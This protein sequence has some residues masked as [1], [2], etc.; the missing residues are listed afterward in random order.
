MLLVCCAHRV[1]QKRC[2]KGVAFS[3]VQLAE[4]VLP[5]A[6]PRKRVPTRSQHLFSGRTFSRAS[7][8]RDA[9]RSDFQSELLRCGSRGG[10]GLSTRNSLYSFNWAASHGENSLPAMTSF[11]S[12]RPS[13][14]L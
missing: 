6:P 2:R 7:G 10:L 5:G 11:R 4:E 12:V 8:I 1:M 13:W 14:S 3:E 9:D